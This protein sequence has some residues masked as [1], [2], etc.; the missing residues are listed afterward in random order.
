MRADIGKNVGQDVTG[1]NGYRRGWGAERVVVVNSFEFVRTSQL[2]LGTP[3]VDA[4]LHDARFEII[5]LCAIPSSTLHRTLGAAGRREGMGA[6]Q[7]GGMGWSLAVS[8]NYGGIV[9]YNSVHRP[10]CE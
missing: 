10:S 9:L 8:V 2:R 7:G 6:L 3:L 1:E 5:F 4:K